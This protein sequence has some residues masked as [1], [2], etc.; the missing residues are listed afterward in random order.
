[1]RAPEIFETE[2]LRLRPVKR[3][4]AGDIYQY[5]S[6]VAE[7]RFMPF[8]RHQ[9]IGDS[10]E[11]AERCEA[12]WVA[13]SA[14]PWAVTE[15]MSERFMGVLELRLSPPKAD[16]GYIF[17]EAFWGNGFATEATSAVVGWTIA[18]PSIMR[19]W[20]T[21]HPGNIASAAVLRRTGLSHEATLSN[22]EARPQL[23]EL[24][25]PSACYAL[26]K[27]PPR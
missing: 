17:A 24:A 22:W 10:L 18:Q 8:Q 23:E 16:F 19:V 14:F 4:D 27:S 12:C 25:G 26:V 2:R 21:C 15:R 9:D 7:T 3:S 1:M 5:T 13:G 11:F 6:G 20:A